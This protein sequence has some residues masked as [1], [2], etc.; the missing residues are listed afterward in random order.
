MFLSKNPVDQTWH[1]TKLPP[2]I[3][4]KK[5]RAISSLALWTVPARAV[6]IAPTRRHPAKVYRGPKRSHA[7]PATSRTRSVATREM[8]L[9]LAMSFWRSFKS[10]AIVMLNCRLGQTGTRFSRRGSNKRLTN[11][12]NAYQDQNATKNPNQENVNTRP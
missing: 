4:T 3:P 2:R 7:G 9:E 8:M 1:G 6:G 12:G 11:G 5:R 10:L